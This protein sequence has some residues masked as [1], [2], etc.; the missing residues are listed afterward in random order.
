MIL[1]F[2][3]NTVLEL[4]QNKVQICFAFLFTTNVRFN[5]DFGGVGNLIEDTAHIM[6]GN[7]K[8]GK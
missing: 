8:L 6:V 2:P 3:E 5:N 4:L 7:G 1:A